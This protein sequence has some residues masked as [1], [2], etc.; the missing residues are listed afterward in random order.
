MNPMGLE[1]EKEALVA[2]ETRLG[3]TGKWVQKKKKSFCVKSSYF[4]SLC[5]LV[6]QAQCQTGGQL[7]LTC[8]NP[9]WAG[10]EF[11]KTLT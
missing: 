8:T 2:I 9:G 3:F 4:G 5:Y 10:W 7:D 1:K 6:T 11:C